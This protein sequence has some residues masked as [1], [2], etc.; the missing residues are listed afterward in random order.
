[1]D[2][3]VVI[4]M[5]PALPVRPVSKYT[6]ILYVC[7]FWL[8]FKLTVLPGQCA[9]NIDWRTGTSWT[10]DN[11]CVS[12]SSSRNIIANAFILLITANINFL[13]EM[14]TCSSI[15]LGCYQ[16]V[17][18][19]SDL[20]QVIANPVKRVHTCFQSRG[21]NRESLILHRGNV[22]FRRKISRPVCKCNS[23]SLHSHIRWQ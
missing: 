9:T 10:C 23:W 16:R 12:H 11:N 20:T 1:V 8:Q 17:K 19:Q 3:L 22:S 5:L 7:I 14:P 18:I 4:L 6:K 21:C 2:P 15:W 13:R